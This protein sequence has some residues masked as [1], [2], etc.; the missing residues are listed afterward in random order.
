MAV[1]IKQGDAYSLPVQ[2]RLGGA[3]LDI[4]NVE[5]VEFCVGGTLRKLFPEDVRYDN[6]TQTFY[7]P[8]TQGETFSFQENA[9]VQMDV[10][11][12]FLGGAVLGLRRPGTI[13]VRDA[14]SEVTL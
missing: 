9:A 10:R 1:N 8:L 13:A 6:G 14:I 7:L 5:L 12:K 4:D 2:I 3:A 11:V